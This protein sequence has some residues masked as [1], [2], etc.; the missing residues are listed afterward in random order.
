MGAQCLDLIGPRAKVLSLSCE[1]H[2]YY[3]RGYKTDTFSN[4]VETVS[5]SQYTYALN[6]KAVT[7]LTPGFSSR[8]GMCF[9]ARMILTTQYINIALR[10]I[11]P[12]VHLRKPCYDFYFL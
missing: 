12:Q 2:K 9:A 11:L 6:K 5:R 1:I 4:A 3:S 7:V 8:D 10:M